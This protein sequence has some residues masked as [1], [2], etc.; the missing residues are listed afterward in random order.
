MVAFTLSCFGLMVWLWL[1]FGGSTPL[2]PQ[3]YRFEATFQ[4]ASLLVEQADVRI[5]G[6]NVG[7][8]ISK[9]LDR[10]AGRTIAEIE[11][12]EEFAPIARDTRVKLREKALLGETY[13]ELA[14]GSPSA[15]RLG[16]GE[17]LPAAAQEESV[18]IDEIV[19]IFDADTRR[20]FRGWIHELARAIEKGRGTDVNAALGHLPNFVASGEDVLRVLADE[21]PVL[22]RLIRNG[23][24]ALG[25]VNERR[26]QLRELIVNANDTME[27]LASRN[28]SLADAVFVLPTFLDESRATLARLRGFAQDTRP[29][30]RD[31]QPVARELRPTLEDVGRLGPELRQVFRNLSPVI[32]E[33]PGT[34]PEAERFVRGAEPV[35]EGLH[36]YL[37]ELNPIL[38]FFNLN[39]SQVSDF[40]MNGASSF[41]PSLP[42]FPGEGPRH[43]LRQYGA[44]N[45][46]SLGINRNRPAYERGNAYPGPDYL[47]RSR[48]FGMTESFD[49]LPSEGE[50]RSPSQGEPPCV[51]QPQS[52]FDG[53]RYPRLGRGEAPV[54]TP[55]GR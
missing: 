8:V 33:S 43:Y 6:L 3:G 21:Q 40:F 55:P 38:A 35:F 50:Q 19:R 11:L 1:S 51:V 9:E 48:R 47:A 4:E 54:L 49:C 29:L 17:R 14:P 22:E 28:E 15:P 34:L 10:D 52:V 36:A 23:G 32:D 42:A 46:R 24:R 25:A 44:I 13:V 16:D 53:L 20:A 12:D 5:A 39:Q 7:K 2:R 30:V 41:G 27:A 31:L 37:P 45:T 18:Q 26:G